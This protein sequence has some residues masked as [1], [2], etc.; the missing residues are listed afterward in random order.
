MTAP[1]DPVKYALRDVHSTLPK[2]QQHFAMSQMDIDEP[3]IALLK[4]ESFRFEKIL[5]VP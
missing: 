2:L 5:L 1:L 3:P 4:S